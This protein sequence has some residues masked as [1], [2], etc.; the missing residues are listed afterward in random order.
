MINDKKA[1]TICLVLGLS[2]ILIFYLI[3]FITG[4]INT[5]IVSFDNNELGFSKYIS[6]FNNDAFQLALVNTFM[7]TVFVVF[8]VNFISLIFAC[9]IK[10]H[11]K[12]SYLLNILILPMIIPTIVIALIFGDIFDLL[13]IKYAFIPIILIFMRKEYSIVKTEFV[14]DETFS[15]LNDL[16]IKLASWVYWYNNHRLH[17][18]L[19]MKTSVESRQMR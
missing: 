13:K 16:R 11:F 18:S 8:S 4:F 5:F 17:G 14:F 15:D 3:P 12:N 6:L 19:G 10:Y 2:G 9:F 1:L 7:F